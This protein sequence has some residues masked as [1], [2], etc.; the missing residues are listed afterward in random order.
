MSLTQNLHCDSKGSIGG[1][2]PSQSMQSEEGIFSSC[3]SSTAL[4]SQSMQA[5]SVSG[6][7][8]AGCRKVLLGS[9]WCALGTALSVLVGSLSVAH[10]ASINPVQGAVTN[11]NQPQTPLLMEG[12]STLYQRVLTT[13]SCQLYP[14]LNSKKYSKELPPFS[15]FYVYADVPN[16]YL[17]GS[18]ATGRIDGYLSKDCIVPWKQ[19][20]GLMFTNPSNRERALIFDSE[21]ALDNVINSNQ[22]SQL[23]KDMLFKVKQGQQVDHVISIEPANYVDYTKQFYLLPIL[24][25][26]ETMFT[27]GSYTYKHEIA[28]VVAQPKPKQQA[29][30]KPQPM[31][32]SIVSFKTAVVFVIDSSISMQ[33]YIDRT[34]EAINTIYRR[35]EAENLNSNVQFGIIAFRGNSKVV[36]ELLYTSMTYLAPGNA[37]NALEFNRAVNSLEQAKVSSAQFNEDAYAGISQALSSV[38]WENYGGRYV[39]L[40]TDAGAIDADDPQSTTKMDAKALR[41]EAESK[42]VAIYSMHLLTNIGKDNHQLAQRQYEELSFNQILNKPLYFPV[43]A[44]SVKSFGVIVDALANSIT[45]QVKQAERGQMSAGSSLAV[46][47]KVETVSTQDSE[48]SDETQRLLDSLSADTEVLGHA[49]QLAY[50][51]RI[52]GTQSPSFMEG[53]ITNRDMVDH[54]QLVCTPVVLVTRNQLSDLYTMVNGVTKAGIAG[55]I[56]TDDMFNQLQSLAA[57]M[58]RDPNQLSKSKDIGEMG[59]MNELLEDLPYK[60]RIASLSPDDWFNLGSQEQESII[61]ELEKSMNY[62]DYCASDNDRWIKLNSFSDEADAVYPI[63]LDALP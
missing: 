11:S 62:L 26:V 44:G 49:M 7:F 35:I 39:V 15:Q 46:S 34:K 6:G 29:Q 20:L 23:Y 31:D 18:N 32:S 58:G 28:S 8:I 57:Q 43:E 45:E 51:G 47:K 50:L 10:A 63:P 56:N 5:G 40:I 36:P 59:L 4:Q 2:V 17:V 53:W 48:V 30:T 54:N 61:R 41:L 9:T 52:E 33:P 12:K 16:Y 13:P 38:N 19:Q 3:I 60:S 21:A 55:Q 37:K 22:S 1:V 42:G 25:S 24:N 27:D 14:D